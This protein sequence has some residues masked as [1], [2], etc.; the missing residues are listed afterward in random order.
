MQLRSYIRT[1]VP[2]ACMSLARHAPVALKKTA[3]TPN[4]FCAHTLAKIVLLAEKWKLYN[5]IAFVLKKYLASAEYVFANVG[6]WSN[7]VLQVR[8]FCIT[9]LFKKRTQ[10]PLPANTGNSRQMLCS[11]PLPANAGRGR[12]VGSGLIFDLPETGALDNKAFD[13][14]FLVL[15]RGFARFSSIFRLLVF[16]K[17]AIYEMFVMCAKLLT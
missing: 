2:G 1:L 8:R 6:Y 7:S 3:K 10:R 15:T 17:F 9:Q 5:R 14:R 13:Y 4:S 12:R 11:G 16:G